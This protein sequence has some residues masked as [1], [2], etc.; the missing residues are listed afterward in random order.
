[1]LRVMTISKPVLALATALIPFSLSACKQDSPGIRLPDL[2]E[3]EATANALPQFTGVYSSPKADLRIH[4]DGRF[5][6]RTYGEGVRWYNDAG[7]SKQHYASCDI[8]R[9]GQLHVIESGTRRFLRLE[10]SERRLLQGAPDPRTP[11]EDPNEIC[12]QALAIWGSAGTLSLWVAAQGEGQFL[13]SNHQNKQMVYLNLDSRSSADG[14]Y[15][16]SNLYGDFALLFTPQGATTDVTD[17]TAAALSA[18]FEDHRSEYVSGEAV[19]ELQLDPEFHTLRLTDG[20]CQIKAVLAYSVVSTGRRLLLRTAPSNRNEATAQ[21]TP[22]GWCDS[23]MKVLTADAP[24]DLFDVTLP[25]ELTGQDPFFSV[26]FSR[27]QP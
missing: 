7:D 24:Q 4:R 17:L 16:D 5:T 18:Q 8:Q 12:A 11:K 21:T 26:Y 15:A 6:L 10:M 2:G 13:I 14:K 1:V 3:Q 22:Q 23:R 20:V 9:Q 25:T 27:R 19:H